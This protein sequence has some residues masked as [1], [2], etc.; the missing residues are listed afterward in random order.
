MSEKAAHTP[1]PSKVLAWL[2]CQVFFGLGCIPWRLRSALGA[3]AGYFYGSLP[4]RDREIA[5]LQLSKIGQLPA[6]RHDIAKVFASAGRTATESLNFTPILKRSATMFSVNDP[7]IVERLRARDRPAVILSAHLGNWEL[8]G[9]YG[10]K[11]GF[12]IFTIARKAQSAPLQVL[13][14]AQR[15]RSGIRVLWRNDNLTRVMDIARKLKVKEYLAALIDQ[16]I[17]VHNLFRPFFGYQASSP[18][19]LIEIAQGF[20]AQFFAAFL[21]REKAGQ[22]RLNIFELESSAAPEVILDQYHRILEAQIRAHPHQWVWFHK[23]WRTFADGRRLSTKEYLRYLED[24]T[25]GEKNVA[26]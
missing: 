21:V 11:L 25:P 26:T 6:T 7:L 3:A 16:D 10:V 1:D 14:A 5:R 22:F 24:L 15:E 9:A 18:D 13:L 2:L 19:G 12:P 20:N 23:R 4:T 8:L 17:H